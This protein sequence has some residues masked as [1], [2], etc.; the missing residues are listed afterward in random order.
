MHKFC[1]ET[2][3]KLGHFGNDSL[4][5]QQFCEKEHTAQILLNR[6]FLIQG[7]TSGIVLLTKKKKFQGVISL[8]RLLFRPKMKNP[9][10][11]FNELMKKAQGCISRFY[12]WT[13]GLFCCLFHKGGGGL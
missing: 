9:K 4:K 2:Y 7:R 6:I 5:C 13:I 10:D 3:R 1:A 11:G 8:K 12:S